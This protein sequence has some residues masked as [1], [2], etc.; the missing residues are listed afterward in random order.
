MGHMTTT[1]SK[2]QPNIRSR[3]HRTLLQPESGQEKIRAARMSRRGRE[4]KQAVLC[5]VPR[6]LMRLARLSHNRDVQEPLVVASS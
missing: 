4:S 6:G 1:P 5:Y 2:C 3:E